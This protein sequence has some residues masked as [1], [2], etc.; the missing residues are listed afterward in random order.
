MC[1]YYRYFNIDDDD[2]HCGRHWV[3]IPILGCSRRTGAI[4]ILSALVAASAGVDAPRARVGIFSGAGAGALPPSLAAFFAAM[5]AIT[6]NQTQ[7]ARPRIKK[8]FP[9]LI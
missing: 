3:G 7:V 6:P 2:G 5:M 8:R 1:H 4:S 9:F